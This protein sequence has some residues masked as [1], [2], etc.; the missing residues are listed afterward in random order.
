LRLLAGRDN[1]VPEEEL[2]SRDAEALR[3]GAL[4]QSDALEPSARQ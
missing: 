1:L 4:Q 3:S 2:V